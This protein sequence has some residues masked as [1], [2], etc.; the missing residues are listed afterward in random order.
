MNLYSIVNRS[1]RAMVKIAYRLKHGMEKK[2]RF[3]NH[4]T[5]LIR[6]R[7]NQL[8]PRGFT[9]KLPFSF[10]NSHKFTYHIS[11][12]LLQQAIRNTRVKKVRIQKEINT[13]SEELRKVSTAKKYEDIMEWCRECAR[14]GSELVKSLR[15]RWSRWE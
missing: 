10:Y 1:Q 3:G 5:F 14:N 4:L 12:A 7:N 13:C 8:I 2:A 6:C 9:I 15:R 11:Q